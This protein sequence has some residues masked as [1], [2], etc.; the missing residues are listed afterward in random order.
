MS[1][2]WTLVDFLDAIAPLGIAEETRPIEFRKHAV[3][4]GKKTCAIDSSGWIV[5]NGKACAR[6]ARITGPAMDIATVMLYPTQSPELLPVFAAE[7]VVF[8]D[9]IHTLVLDV[10]V[11]GN[12]PELFEHLRATFAHA[13]R[14]WVQQFPLNRDKPEWFADIETP[15][16]LF[17]QAGGESMAALRSAFRNYLD[18]TIDQVYRRNL[19]VAGSGPDRVEVKAYKDH[20]YIN[21]PGHRILGVRFGEHHTDKLLKD[22]HFGP[23]HQPLSHPALM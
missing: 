7:W 19:P 12:Q 4:I 23:S 22:W 11:C 6:Y 8:G 2:E 20:H 13:H 17:G 18:L 21:S 14:H 5:A 9:K 16:A 10:E 15:W 3:S 1:T